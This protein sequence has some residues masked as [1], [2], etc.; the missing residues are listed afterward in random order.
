MSGFS[1]LERL[2]E[3]TDPARVTPVLVV[4]ADPSV[5]SRRRAHLLGATDYLV[6][7]YET[8]VVPSVDALLE[9]R[10]HAN[11]AISR[12]QQPVGAQLPA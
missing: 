6:K 10:A 4:T 8:E 1:L 9:M 2:P 12:S 3:T 7:P 5:E 11:A